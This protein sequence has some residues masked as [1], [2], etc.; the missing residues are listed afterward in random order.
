MSFLTAPPSGMG[1][2]DAVMN[3]L[4]TFVKADQNLDM[5]TS[6]EAEAQSAEVELYHL[7]RYFKAAWKIDLGYD[8]IIKDYNRTA[9]SVKDEVYN[10][11]L[12][13]MEVMV[14]QRLDM[15]QKQNNDIL[16]KLLGK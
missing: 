8:K 6:I 12:Q 11:T 14:A 4:E 10:R 2:E 9:V 16:S 3:T 1:N 13:A 7:N 15:A 5:K